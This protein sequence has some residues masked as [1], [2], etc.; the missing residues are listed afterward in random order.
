MYY[1]LPDFPE[2]ACLLYSRFVRRVHS[3]DMSTSWCC[4]VSLGSDYGAWCRLTVCRLS[5]RAT[6]ILSITNNPPHCCPESHLLITICHLS[7]APPSP[8]LFLPPSLSLAVFS[9][10][11]SLPAG[12]VIP[13]TSPPLPPLHPSPQ[14]RSPSA[15]RHGPAYRGM[16]SLSSLKHTQLLARSL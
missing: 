4:A 13:C 11:S 1:F 2:H 10:P 12:P 6:L 7:D 14:L 16:F 5:C 9:S 3:V 15:Q 8:S